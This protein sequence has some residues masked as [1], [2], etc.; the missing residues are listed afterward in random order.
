[1]LIL[2]VYLMQSTLLPDMHETASPKLP[3][4]F[5]STCGEEVDGVRAFFQHQPGVTQ[6]LDLMP[7][8]RGD[9]FQ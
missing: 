4:V 9:L 8:Y 7:G 5:S 3:N 1:M 6:Q 2:A